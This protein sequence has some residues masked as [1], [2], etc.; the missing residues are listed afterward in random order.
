MIISDGTWEGES[1]EAY[2][3]KARPEERPDLVRYR[4]PIQRQHTAGSYQN[5]QVLPVLHELELAQV[6]TFPPLMT[7]A[8]KADIFFFT[9]LRLHCGH[10]R[11]CVSS[12]VRTSSSNS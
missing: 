8:A 4:I 7:G 6:D 9:S 2:A 3:D 11:L 5:P 10:T 1:L 12:E